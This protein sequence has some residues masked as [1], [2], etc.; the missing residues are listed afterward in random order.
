[1]SFVEKITV[2]LFGLTLYLIKMLVL[3]MTKF[4]VMSNRVL[5]L[6]RYVSLKICLIS[7]PNYYPHQLLKSWYIML[8]CVGLINYRTNICHIKGVFFK[9]SIIFKDY[10]KYIGKWF[11]V[12]FFLLIRF[13]S[14]KFY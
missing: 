14:S 3:V 11:I 1:M 9:R 13:Y 4:L 12:F 7:L 10:E 5:M 2:W 6:N 8:A